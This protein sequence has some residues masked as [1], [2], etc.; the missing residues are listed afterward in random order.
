MTI[1]DSESDA[2]TL[3]LELR[4]P[5]W[6]RSGAPQWVLTVPSQPDDESAAWDVLAPIFG[7]PTRTER[8]ALSS[9]LDVHGDEF[10]GTNE[11][12]T[13][14]SEI[15]V[16]VEGEDEPWILELAFSVLIDGANEFWRVTLDS[17]EDLGLLRSALASVGSAVVLAQGDSAWANEVSQWRSLCSEREKTTDDLMRLMEGFDST[18]L[19]PDWRRLPRLPAGW[20]LLRVVRSWLRGEPRGHDEVECALW[21]LEGRSRVVFDQLSTG[22]GDDAVK[23]SAALVALRSTDLPRRVS[24]MPHPRSREYENNLQRLRRETRWLGGD[25]T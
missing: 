1:S 15:E 5:P 10:F 8:Y 2:A 6:H 11:V 25:E 22:E 19:V 18:A 24:P 17:R 20:A 7:V 16:A 4:P 13:E 14:I 3:R 12:E 23:L 21:L 9:H